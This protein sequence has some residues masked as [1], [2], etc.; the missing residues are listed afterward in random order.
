MK[1]EKICLIIQDILWLHQTDEISKESKKIIQEHLK[2]CH[3]CQKIEEQIKKENSEQGIEDK[4]PCH[5]KFKE[6]AYKLRKKRRRNI[7][8]TLLVCGTLIVTTNLAFENYKLPFTSMQP[9]IKAGEY[10]FINKLA[11]EWSSPVNNDIVYV[12]LKDNNARW[13]DM[14]RVI[15]IP[16]DTVQIKDGSV[17]VNGSLLEDNYLVGINDGGRAT[18]EI[19]V[20]EGKYFIMGDD[21]NNSYDSRYFGC[22][23]EISIRGK[24]WFTW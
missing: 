13:N 11:Y 4:H 17:Y 20:E 3:E 10:C 2:E 18:Q 15:G 14:Y 7:I 24:L 9:T 23:D 12:S 19:K 1:Q 16:G 5:D 6:I 8:I 22:I 21:V